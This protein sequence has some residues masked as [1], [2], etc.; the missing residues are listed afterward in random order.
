MASLSPTVAPRNAGAMSAAAPRPTVY[1]TVK[2]PT[3][4]AASAA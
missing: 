4:I 2:Y 3:V 1:H